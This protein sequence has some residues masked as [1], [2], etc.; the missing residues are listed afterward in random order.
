M[1]RAVGRRLRALPVRADRLFRA[2]R[3]LGGGDDRAARQADDPRRGCADVTGNSS[4][5]GARLQIWTCTG[6]ANQ[7]WTL[8]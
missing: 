7:K 6:A 2:H 4:A 1:L 8:S 3:L 5:D